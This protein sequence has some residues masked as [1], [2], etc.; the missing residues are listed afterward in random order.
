MAIITISRGSKSGGHALAECLARRLDYPIVGREVIQE[1][2]TQLGVSEEEV[3]QGMEHTPKLWGRRSLARRLYVTA[4]QA[5]LA[6]RIVDGNL[7]YHGLAGQLLLR[8]LPAVLRLRLIAPLE[9]RIATLM[10]ND[11]MD[12]SSAHRYIRDM[13][14]ARA[15]WVTMMYDQDINDPA[16][17]DLVINLEVMSLPTACVLIAKAAEQPAFVADD[18]AKAKL[19]SFSLA[20]QARVA[21]LS[22][23]QTRGLDLDVKADDGVVEVSGSL[24]LSPT[25]QLENRISQIVSDVPGVRATRLQIQWFSQ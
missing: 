17:Y 15:R 19:A 13:D 1:A 3:G 5:A 20:C 7:V 25:G 23:P 8:G 18:A 2:A 14:E 10:E 21:L 16:L 11:S 4:V 9:T 22:D 12:R 24:T 6:Q